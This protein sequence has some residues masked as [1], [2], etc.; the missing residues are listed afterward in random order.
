MPRHVAAFV[1]SFALLLASV[2]SAA[3]APVVDGHFPIPGG[4]DANSKIVEGPDGNVWMTVRGVATDVAR[5]SPAGKVDEF[6]IP[7]VVSASGIASGPE[8]RL[9]ITQIGGVASFSPANPAGG[10]ATPIVGVNGNA[11]IVAGPDGQMW[12]ATD[13]QVFHFAP[14][15]PSEAK[16]VSVPGLTP[17]DID[18]AGQLLAI[19]DG[20]NK[21][22]VTLTTTGTVG[23]IP[24]L[25][26]TTTSQGVAGSPGGQIAFSKSDNPEGLALA[27]PPG[28]APT[29]F[30]MAGDP[31]GVARGSDEAFWF[32]MSADDSLRRLTA[33]GQ[34]TT[35]KGFPP[36]FFPRQIAAGPGNTLWVTMEIP[37]ENVFEVARV[38]GLEPPVVKPPEEKKPQP[39]E[40]VL[41]GPKG[42]LLTRRPRAK[43]RFTFS[44]PTAGASFECAL[45]RLSK[46]KAKSA[47]PPKFRPCHSPRKLSLQPGRYRFSVRAVA[48]GLA[49]PTP[50]AHTLRVVR[51]RHR[52]HR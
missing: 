8:G 13:E 41:K 6:E 24:L 28:F 37:G 50:A 32:A 47:P 34:V 23:E 46:G 42:K 10:E 3:A 49:D 1:S 18:V 52:A 44:S 7:G 30:E 27:S 43:A 12:V 33:D 16:P 25:G 9:W 11:S 38:S 40:T 45:V 5:I 20:G 4:F 15:A 36:K 14:S 2:A 35:L 29:P 39:P 31:F 17:H 48:G 19:A 21:R 26:G 51:L 22:I